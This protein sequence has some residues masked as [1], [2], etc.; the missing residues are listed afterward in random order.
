LEEEVLNIIENKNVLVTGGGGF[1]G[2]NL[3]EE[4]SK[5]NNVSIIDNLSTGKRNYIQDFKADFIEGSITDLNT[6]KMA[7]KDMDYVF[8]LAALASVPRSVKEPKIVN[9]VNITGTVNVL[10]AAKDLNVKKVVFASSSSVYGDTPT[11]PK[12]E[13]MQP[14]PLSPYAVS[15]LSGEYY[16]KVFYKVYGLPTTSLRFFNVYGPR[17]DPSSEY[18]A[19]IPKFI[20]LVS[21]NKSPVIFG[22]GTQTRDFTF[23]KDVV[24]ALILSAESEKANGEVINIAGGKRI[25]IKELAG[26]ITQMMGKDIPYEYSDKR[27]GDI[28]HSLADISKASSL[29]GF[30]PTYSLEKGLEE[31]IGFFRN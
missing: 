26:K 31:T 21:E 2:S 27:P 11:L 8:H 4:L 6:L 10:I 17:Q 18:A 22:D 14:N 23:V 25:S 29:I 9:E 13:T 19:V 1:I 20:Q 3:A 30:M 16:C 24:K 7:C 5:N 28:E 15:K 12:V